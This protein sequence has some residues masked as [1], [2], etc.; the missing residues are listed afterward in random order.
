MITTFLG[1]E[2]G[3]S[4]HNIE[5]YPDPTAYRAL[6]NLQRAEYG[7]RPLVYICS[8]YSGDVEANMEL[9][10]TFCAHAVARCKIPLAP[11]LLFPQFMDDNDPETRELAMFFNRILL[12]KCEA[13]WVYMARVSVGMRVEIEWAHHFDLPIKYF[14]ADFEEVTP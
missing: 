3:F 13:I 14:D 10:R 5:G 1:A 12:S 9:A 8:P 6:K 7:Y 4:P 2:L 11:H